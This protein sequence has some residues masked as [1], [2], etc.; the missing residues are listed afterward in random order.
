M[1][2]LLFS[3]EVILRPHVG[4]NACRTLANLYNQRPAHCHKK[5]DEA[6]IAAYGW[7]PSLSDEELLGELLELNLA[8]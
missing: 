5:L 6:V 7:S 8:Q 3:A 4:P 2:A 1:R